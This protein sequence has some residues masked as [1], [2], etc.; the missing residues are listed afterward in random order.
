MQS[1]SGPGPVVVFFMLYRLLTQSFHFSGGVRSWN[2][3][4]S[5]CTGLFDSPL[6]L[7]APNIFHF[8]ARGT[9]ILGVVE[10]VKG[11]KT[12]SLPFI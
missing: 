8:L 10:T 4:Y 11:E 2:F 3:A 5:L 6:H 1:E 7:D 9:T 12:W